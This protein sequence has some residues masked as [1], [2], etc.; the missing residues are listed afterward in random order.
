M[1]PSLRGLVLAPVRLPLL[2]AAVV[3]EKGTDVVRAVAPEPV[4]ELVDGFGREAAALF[5][6]RAQRWQRRI[7]VRGDRIHA[8]VKG[9][10]GERAAE[11]GELLSERL[12]GHHAVRWLRVNAVNG[13]VTVQTEPD[14]LDAGELDDALSELERK[15]GTEDIPWSRHLTDPSDQEPVFT[16]AAQLAGDVIGIGLAV[17]GKVIPT[18]PVADFVRSTVSLVD[19]QPQLR[20]MLERQLG[21]HRADTVLALGNAVGQ[22]LDSQLSALLADTLQ[23]TVR[24]VEATA[25]YSQWRRWD[26]LLATPDQPGVA[27]Y[28]SPA[29]RPVILPA[30]PIE[31]TASQIGAAAA[32]ASLATLTGRRGTSDAADALA[33]GVP[34]AARAGRETFAGVL[35]T[36]MTRHG[37]LTI[38]PRLWRRLDRAS[39]LVVD[40]H[41]LRGDRPVVLSAE[42]LDPTWTVEHVWSASQRLLRPNGSE[43]PIPPPPG[44]HRETLRLEPEGSDEAHA[45]GNAAGEPNETPTGDN[46]SVGEKR[47]RRSAGGEHAVRVAR[48]SDNS[49]VAE[50]DPAWHRLYEG[51]EVVGRALIGREAH[52]EALGLLAAARRAGLRVVLLGDESMSELRRSADEFVTGGGSETALVRRLQ[53]QGHVVAV[54]SGRAHKALGAADLGIGLVEREGGQVRV[55]WQADVVCPDLECARRII[56]AV[57]PARAVSERGRVLALSAATLTGLLLASGPAGARPVAAT[58]PLSSA[59]GL[60]S[61]SGMLA[62]RSAARA[63]DVTAVPL[64]PWHALEADEVLAR[65][66]PPPEVSAAH[67]AVASGAIRTARWFATPATTLGELATQ[68]RRELADPLTP[69]LAVGAVASALLGSPTDAV[70]VGSVLGL[71]AVVS[72]LQRRR[73]GQS[74]HRLLVGE[75]LLARR[76][77][78]PRER[79]AVESGGEAE[80]L[81]HGSDQ[82]N[83]DGGSGAVGSIGEREG[84]VA[85]DGLRVG[86]VIVLRAG[87]VVPA[88]A[89]LL[90]AEGLEVDESGLTGESV[91]VEK[92]VGATPGAALGDRSCMVFEG[93]VVVNGQA[94]AVVVAVGAGTEAGRAL[95]AAGAPRG[96]GVQAQLKS[97]SSQVLPLTLGG[98]SVVAAASFLRGLPLRPALADGL[99]VAVAAVPEGLPLVATVAQLAATRRLSRHGVL[100]RSS[101]TIEA[102]GRLDTVC[103]DKTGT[104]TAGRLHLDAL[105]DADETWDTENASG[106]P[107]SRRLLRAAARACPHEDDGP[108]HATD[109]AVVDAADRLLGA[110]AAHT[111]DPIEEVPFESNRG[112]AAAVGHTAHHIRL[113]VKGAPEVLLPRCT[114]VLRANGEGDRVITAFDAEQRADAEAAVQRLAERGLRVL[115]VARRDFPRAPAEVAE[116]IEQLTLL[117]FIGLA[118]TPRPQTPD[119]VGQLARNDISVRMITGDHPVTA[120]AVARQ[121]G[122]PADEVATGADIDALDEDEQTEFIDRATVFARV[123]PE[124]KVRIVTALQRRGHVVAMTGDGS[125]DAAAIRSADIGIGLAARGS[126]AAREA[127]DLI[128]TGT[129]VSDADRGGE[130]ADPA[131]DLDLTVLLTA[132]VEGRGMWQRVRDAIGVLV[133][134]NAGEVTFTVLGTLLSGK[135]PIGT[136]QFLLVNLLTD[137]GPAMA[138]ALSSTRTS[139]DAAEPADT[140]S[141]LGELPRPELGG[142]FLRTVAVRGACTTAGAGAAWLLG[143]ATGTQ[144]RAATMALAALVSTQLGQTLVIGRHSPLVWVTAAG[145]T[146][147]LAEIIMTPGVNRFFGCVALDPVAWAIVTGCAV[148]GTI[149]AVYAGHALAA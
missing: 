25:R 84:E 131:D 120:R 116:E 68:V 118:D 90:A 97:L 77:E 42:P 93:G 141:E 46:T 49:G 15:A 83:L 22:A 126:V 102:L 67:G 36:L 132:L 138:V 137:L 10:R 123:T 99:A 62:G 124:H 12:G 43:L 81:G 144:R 98:G 41:A 142:D 50:G 40:R 14:R 51:D 100:V 30:G 56:A 91:T 76:V 92:E 80:E 109:R 134:G 105:A 21:V 5:D 60:S 110:K 17:A 149:G 45:D 64:V 31:Q 7:S 87:A 18:S 71:N 19:G 108:T 23:R 53:K 24:L 133:G 101:R 47:G 147:L 55:P 65:L 37:V 136:R 122:I 48:A 111:W 34:R 135:A 20:R 95:A 127:A 119:L 129:P 16:S 2:A 94:R 3:A 33:A 75:R 79:R 70:L 9:L 72:A 128:I 85:A 143:R 130:S 69:L 8:E 28:H 82:G 106:S 26:S 63:S 140:G 4:I 103:F 59:T 57:G 44:R 61:V 6:P 88:D 115:V 52:P 114:Q 39:A 139:A 32:A 35:S 113:A 58:A 66:P 73:A 96:G 145:S 125:N 74:L 78:N 86:D 148:G 38:D 107:Q 1:T 117:G 13:R 112:Y 29:P 89:R 121:L 27:E 54:L 11:I 104:L 146:A